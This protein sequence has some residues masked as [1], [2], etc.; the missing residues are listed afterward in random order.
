MRSSSTRCGGFRT[1]FLEQAL[2]KRGCDG[3]REVR[4]PI[5]SIEDN[6]KLYVASV[7]GATIIEDFKGKK[8][9]KIEKELQ[10]GGMI[11]SEEKLVNIFEEYCF[12]DTVGEVESLMTEDDEVE[13]VVN[14]IELFKTIKEYVQNEEAQINTKYKT[15]EKKVRPVATPLPED[16]EKIMKEVS[17]EPILRDP[18]RIG[19]K[20]M[21]ETIKELRIGGEDFLKPIE[22]AEFRKMLG[23]HG[24]AFSFNPEEIGCVNPKVVEPMVIFTIPHI[25]RNLKPI[26]VPRARILQLIEILKV[27]VKIG[28]LEPSNAPYSSRWFTV[29]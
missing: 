28:I 2:T 18:K 11:D 21:E 27:K 12:K 23:Q 8:F 15:V 3:P 6:G 1:G 4:S 19:H 16:S 25:P 17:T 9:Q 26:P 7:D 13:V 29:Q 20:F 24:K 10:G 5:H 22:E 14:S